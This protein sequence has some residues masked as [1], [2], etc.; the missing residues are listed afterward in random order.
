[1]GARVAF[2]GRRARFEFRIRRSTRHC[3]T[4]DRVATATAT[5][6]RW[7]ARAATRSDARGRAR[8]ATREDD[9]ARGRETRDDGD[10]ERRGRRRAIRDGDG[11]DAT[12]ET[13]ARAATRRRTIARG[14]RTMRSGRA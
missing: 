6:T 1:M 2:G 11:D 9:D 10:D 14:G 3:A 7:S 12:R 4:T 13:R 8:D 5:A